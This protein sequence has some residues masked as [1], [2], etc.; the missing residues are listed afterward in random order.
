MGA[1]V[2]VLLAPTAG[3]ARRVPRGVRCTADVRPFVH[4]VGV[5]RR[6]ARR[7]QHDVRSAAPA[8]RPAVP[9]VDARTARGDGARPGPRARRRV[10]A[11]GPLLDPPGRPQPRR[12]PAD[13]APPARRRAGELLL[14]RERDACR[15]GRALSG[16]RPLHAHR[17]LG[18]A[19]LHRAERVLA[20]VPPAVRRHPDAVAGHGPAYRGGMSGTRGAGPPPPRMDHRVGRPGQPGPPLSRAGKPRSPAPGE[21]GQARTPATRRHEVPPGMRSP[22]EKVA[23]PA[24]SG[25]RSSSSENTSRSLSSYSWL[26][27]VSTRTICWPSKASFT[28]S[29]TA[30]EERTNSA[31]V[32]GWIS[33]RILRMNESSMPTSVM[34]PVSAPIPAPIAMPS[35]GTKKI[36]PNSMPQTAPPS[37][38]APAR[39]LSWRV[40]GF[41]A[42][43]G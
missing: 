8:L 28:L 17:G 15:L 40:F 20:V 22:G 5:H 21:A 3:N 41:F 38:P 35:S 19:R 39:F 42:P 25:V 26:R 7:P 10:P 34:L 24:G 14:D 23:Q 1:P 9:G 16:E 37:A 12:H 33:S 4:R 2:G 32:P 13:P 6:P 18:A 30:P 36:S 29:T 31:E 27:L 11:A 43:S